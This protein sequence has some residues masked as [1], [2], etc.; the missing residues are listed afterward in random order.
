LYVHK[1]SQTSNCVRFRKMA[2]SAAPSSVKR[3]PL[4]TKASAV[5][6]K[7][8]PAKKKAKYKGKPRESFAGCIAPSHCRNC[9]ESRR[10]AP[11]WNPPL[12]KD[13]EIEGYCCN[14]P[15]GCI[16]YKEGFSEAVSDQSGWGDEPT[17]KHKRNMVNSCCCPV[18]TPIPESDCGLVIV[19]PH[20]CTLLSQ[21]WSVPECLWWN[22]P[23]AILLCFRKC[24]PLLILTG[25]WFRSITALVIAG[26]VRTCLICHA[27]KI[28]RAAAHHRLLEQYAHNSPQ[29]LLL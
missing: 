11:K 16:C 8:E 19:L 14:E 24:K 26:R 18:L 28:E 21:F 4:S 29:K 7:K 5:R 10:I 12:L 13:S 17:P 3:K 22:L 9:A 27:K 2:S 6:V 1:I 25:L 23:R 15:D 20:H